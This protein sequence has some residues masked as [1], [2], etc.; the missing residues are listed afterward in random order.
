VAEADDVAE[1][2][3]LDEAGSRARGSPARRQQLSLQI[4][5]RWRRRGMMGRMMRRKQRKRPLRTGVLLRNLQAHEVGAREPGEAAEGKAR[6]GVGGSGVS[7]LGDTCLYAVYL[8]KMS[9]RLYEVENLKLCI[10]AP[11]VSPI[12]GA[13]E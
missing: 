12:E 9:I 3:G 7:N 5:R 4:R 13:P 6:V 1:G 2:E 11:S 10:I 8:L